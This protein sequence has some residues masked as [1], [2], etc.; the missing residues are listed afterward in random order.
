MSPFQCLD[1][2][3]GGITSRTERGQRVPKEATP[4]AMQTRV[5][6]RT[7]AVELSAHDL[8]AGDCCLAIGYI[9]PI[10]HVYTREFGGRALCIADDIISA[11]CAAIAR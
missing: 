9:K 11:V 3:E 4:F 5:F 6:A 1:W 2:S 10:V 7:P 8:G